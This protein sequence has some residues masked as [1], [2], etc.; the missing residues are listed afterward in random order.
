MGSLIDKARMWTVKQRL[1]ELETFLKLF[2]DSPQ[3]PDRRSEKEDLEAELEN[4][5]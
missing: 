1:R 5:K 4:L 3:A 2:P